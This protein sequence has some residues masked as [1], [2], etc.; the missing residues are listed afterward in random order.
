MRWLSSAASNSAIVAT[1]RTSE[2]VKPT[3]AARR[4]GPDGQSTPKG[5]HEPHKGTGW[6]NENGA[7]VRWRRFES[8]DGRTYLRSLIGT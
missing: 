3:I 7:I 4:I 5:R 2:F 1:E 6:A 8:R